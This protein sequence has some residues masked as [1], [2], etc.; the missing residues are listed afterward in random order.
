MQKAG[1]KPGSITFKNM[2]PPEMVAAWAQ[3]SIQAAY[4]WVPFFTEMIHDGG[5]ALLYDED[6]SPQAPIFNLAV[7]NSTWAKSH[8]GLVRGFIRAEAA[9]Y[10]FYKAHPHTAYQDMAAVNQ[11]T[12][13][14]AQSQASGL[15]FVSLQG[16]LNPQE[17]LGTPQTVSSSLVTQSL[18]AAAQYLYQTQAISQVPSHIA[19]YVN[20]AYVQEVIASGFT[21]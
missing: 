19:S 5:K 7:V 21:G 16:Q 9:G 4:V 15:H 1:M 18:R 2:T 8:P 10:A 20:P 6:A 17:G 11:I 3:G 13:Q 14:Q 12:A